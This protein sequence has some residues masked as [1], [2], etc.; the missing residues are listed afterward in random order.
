[1][2]ARLKEDIRCVMDRDPAARN[3]F[4]VL[5]CYPG[6]HAILLHRINHWLWQ[7]GLRWLARFFG[8]IARWLTGIEIHPGA[9]IGRRFFIDHGMGVVIGE[10]A[11][12]GDGCMLCK[13]VTH[14][15][16]RCAAV[17]RHALLEVDVTSGRME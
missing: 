1:M 5:T 3:A 8:M 6:L 11:E 4:E 16:N 7:R 13:G 12:I 14:I 10:T 17:K 15:C 2:F 9:R